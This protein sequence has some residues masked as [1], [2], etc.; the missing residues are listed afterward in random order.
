M[1]GTYLCQCGP[2]YTVDDTTAGPYNCQSGVFFAYTHPA[3][4]AAS[5]L[6]RRNLRARLD[7]LRLD[8]QKLCPGQMKACKL[9]DTS[10]TYEC[11]DTS[12]ELESCGGCLFGEYGKDASNSTIGTD[13]STLHGVSLG[14]ATCRDT[15]CEAYACKKGYELVSGLCVATVSA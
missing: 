15:V 6:A 14:A 11:V 9:E 7:Q 3:A 10:D 4:A 8:S 1:T 13:C 2:D 5:D 12:S